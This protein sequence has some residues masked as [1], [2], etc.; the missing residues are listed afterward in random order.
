MQRFVLSR[1]GQEHEATSPLDAI[2]SNK[3]NNIYNQ[4]DAT[5]TVYYWFQSAQHVLGDDFAH[6]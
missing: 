3:G 6:T 1:R 5:I 4:L 2:K